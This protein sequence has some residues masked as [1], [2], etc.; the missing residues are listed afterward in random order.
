M[1]RSANAFLVLALASPAWGAYGQ[2]DP[3]LQNLYEQ[4]IAPC[5]W[6]QNLTVHESQAADQLRAAILIMEKNGRTDDEIKAVL[7]KQYGERILALPE[8]AARGWLFA[9]PWVVLG[10]AFLGLVTLLRRLP[11][12]AAASVDLPMP[13]EEDWEEL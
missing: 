1:V 9:V 8:G 11:R 4:I 13:F 12:P 2:G 3:R 5:C 7:V 6:R 10:V